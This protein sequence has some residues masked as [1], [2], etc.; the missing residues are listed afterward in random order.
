M[1]GKNRQAEELVELTAVSGELP[2]KAVYRLDGGG[3]Y[4]KKLVINLK[5][6]GDIKTHYKNGIRGYRLTAKSKKELMQNN[7]DR[8]GFYLT[9]DVD[10]NKIQSGVTRRLRLHRIANALVTVYNSGA[11]IFRDK[12]YGLFNSQNCNKFRIDKPCYYTSR[13]FKEIGNDMVKAKNARAVGIL[14]TGTEILMVYN[15]EDYVMKWDYGSELDVKSVVSRYLSDKRGLNQKINGLLLGNGMEMLLSVLNENNGNKRGYFFLDN[16]FDSFIYLTNDRYGEILL[17]LFY[18][19]DK[20]IEIDEILCENLHPPDRQY[21]TENDA[22]DENGNPVLY[23]YLPDMP[24]L[25]RY[26]NALKLHERTGTVICFDFQKEALAK[27][28]GEQIIFDTIDFDEFERSFFS[29]K[30]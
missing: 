4:K 21:I 10:T 26:V 16:A 19:R 24:R 17:K 8:F 15:T 7:P 20:R 9:G 2:S 29:E 14:F 18:D 11:E 5:K 12:K 27:Y 25:A 1:S 22:I 3:Y 6:S 28:C 23:S 30:S 13:E